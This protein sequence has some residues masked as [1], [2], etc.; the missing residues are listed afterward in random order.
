MPAKIS[1]NKCQKYLELDREECQVDK[2]LIQKKNKTQKM[3]RTKSIF[4]VKREKKLKF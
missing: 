1:E 3:K 2:F 4:C